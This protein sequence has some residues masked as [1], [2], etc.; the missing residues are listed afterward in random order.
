MPTGRG[1]PVF[2]HSF[3]YPTACSFR[4]PFANA[5]PSAC[6]LNGQSPTQHY[7]LLAN[8]HSLTYA[9]N[10]LS[11][12]K[13]FSQEMKCFQ[14]L[15]KY[16]IWSWKA[17]FNFADSYF[18]IDF[19]LKT[20]FILILKFFLNLVKKICEV[21]I[22]EIFMKDYPYKSSFWSKVFRLLLP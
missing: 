15:W 20:R 21:K 8:Q 4:R 19:F 1:S 9:L 5:K 16:R 3:F 13:Q 2:W 14:F 17:E 12:L 22:F 18:F 7:L 11:E 6:T 10:F